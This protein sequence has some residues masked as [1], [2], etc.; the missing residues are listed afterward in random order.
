[1]SHISY[2]NDIS[3][4]LSLDGELKNQRKPRWTKKNENSINMNN[5]TANR[6]KLSVSYSSSVLLNNTTLNK[7]P[8]KQEKTGNDKK[9]SGK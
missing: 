7:T 8:N 1:M 4:L 3:N 5:S 9:S 2:Q 6:S